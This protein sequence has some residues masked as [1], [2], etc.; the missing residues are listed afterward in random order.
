VTDGRDRA[1]RNPHLFGRAADV[2]RL[3]ELLVAGAV[4]TAIG[5]GGV[6][7]TRL[8][9]EVAERRRDAGHPVRTGLLVDLAPGADADA[10]ADA[11]GFESTD[12]AAVVLADRPELLV[13][14]NCEHLLDAVRRFLAAVR[15]TAPE[16]AVLTTSREPLDVP[17]ERV[18]VVPPLGLPPPGGGDAQDSPAVQLFLDR[19][20]AAGAVLVPTPRLLTDIG[21]LCRRLDGLPLAIEL[22]AARTRAIA[23]GDLLAVVDQRLDLLRRSRSA[24]DR[25]DSMRAAIEV[26]TAMLGEDERAFFRRL[27]V[28]RGPFDLD[29]AHR[30]A[31][32][33][34]GSALDTLDQLSSLVDRSL[35]VAEVSGGATRYRL[36]ELLREH[37]ESELRAADETGT[38]EERFIDTML[39][40]AADLVTRALERWDPTVLAA[41]SAQFTNLS[42]ACELCIVRDQHPERCFPLMV[43]LFAAVHEGRAQDVHALGTRVLARWPD[44][45]APWRAE[46]VGVVATATALAGRLGE[47]GPLA[48]LVVDDPA[49]SPVALALARRAWGLATRPD[50]PAIARDHFQAARAA[51]EE[52]RFTAVARELQALEAGEAD[53]AG[54]RDEAVALLDDLLDLC[55]LDEDLFVS[56]LAHLVRARIWLRAGD[57]TA[58]ATDLAAAERASQAMEQLWWNGAILRTRAA[59]ASLSPAGWTNGAPHWRAAVDFAAGIG[60]LGEV[61]IALRAAAS[62]AF[63]LG[64]LDAAQTL[65]GAA[66]SSTAITVLPELFPDAVAALESRTPAA[67]PDASPVDALARARAALG[68][69]TGNEPNAT[70]R[71]RSSDRDPSVLGDHPTAATTNEWVREGDVWRVTFGGQTVRIRHIK[72]L[73][74]LATL[75]AQPGTERHALELMG[76]AD[77]TPDAGPQVDERARREYQERIVELQRDIDEAHDHNDTARAERAEH[78]LDAL[79]AQLSEAFGLGGRSRTTGSSAERARSAVTYRIRS[80]IRKVAEGHPDLGR[81]LKNAVRTGTWCCYQPETDVTWTV[82][83]GT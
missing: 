51:A 16:C 75:L 7:K 71:R 30:V 14:D 29:L 61:A 26:S 67:P 3:D 46:A 66:P 12:A 22:A 13:L 59:L 39:D 5:P 10:V 47:V 82:V 52:A 40:V 45:L 64:E 17:G 53:L 79:V 74:D 65:Y 27:A 80:A 36:L 73:A 11:L 32:E 50:G 41:A 48:R 69:T 63:H 8:V 2:D 24:G 18:V 33:P 81:H 83:N 1:E 37:A 35:V 57:T 77:T 55:R 70:P 6:G 76:G 20:D 78:E 4:L 15:S 38:L 21:E 25:H 44:D 34:G 43:P 56:I 58:A 68:S 62:V 28:F 23:P 54:Q 72:G 49:A 9:E 60:A 42:R 31:G 19:A